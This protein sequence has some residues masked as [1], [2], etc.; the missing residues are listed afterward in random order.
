MVA[1]VRIDRVLFSAAMSMAEPSPRSQRR[2]IAMAIGTGLA[3]LLVPLLLGR[4]FTRDDLAAL[5]L[6]FR[7]LYQRALVDGHLLWW[8]DAYHSGFFIHGAGEA[9]IT[10]PLHMALY[11]FLPLGPAFNLE[12]IASYMFLLIGTALFMKRLGLSADAALF[13]GATFAFGSFNIF[14][15]MHV[16]HIAT[17]AHEPWMLL[18]THRI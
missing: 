12:I 15:L 14:N 18:F 4:V 10:H 8:T 7:F 1:T 2:A 3:P 16:N 11:R 13:G 6:P 5:H 9:G 17:F